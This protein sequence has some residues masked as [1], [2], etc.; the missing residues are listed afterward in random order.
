MPYY[1]Y[2]CLNEECRYVQTIKASAPLTGKDL[3]ELACDKCHSHMER[4]FSIFNIPKGASESMQTIGP[5]TVLI[6]K[7]LAEGKIKSP[8]GCLEAKCTLYEFK[9]A[10]QTDLN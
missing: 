2:R 8:C 1:E 10:K 7:K 5:N 6:K 4:K 9:I 3:E